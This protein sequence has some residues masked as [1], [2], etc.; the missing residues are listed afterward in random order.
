[1]IS[2]PMMKKASCFVNANGE[3]QKVSLEDY[4]SPVKRNG[5]L[6]YGDITLYYCVFSK[7]GFEENLENLKNDQLLLFSNEID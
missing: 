3:R 7:S 6:S 4:H 5:Y 1:M 2:L